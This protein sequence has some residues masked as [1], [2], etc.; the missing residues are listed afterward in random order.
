MKKNA[1][2]IISLLL[3]IVLIITPA[4]ASLYSPMKHNTLKISAPRT[5]LSGFDV[6]DSTTFHPFQ[7]QIQKMN[8]TPAPIPQ[9]SLNSSDGKYYYNWGS[10]RFTP[11]GH[12]IQ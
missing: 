9:M 10:E 7:L 2:Y 11:G 4:A 6:R 1:I 5:Y 12:W 8:L 3:A